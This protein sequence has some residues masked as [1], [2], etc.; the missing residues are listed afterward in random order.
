[1][2]M[3]SKILMT[4]LR[5]HN[6]RHTKMESIRQQLK[7]SRMVSDNTIGKNFLI[8]GWTVGVFVLSKQ[9]N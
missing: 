1:M 3:S 7:Q 5:V 9:Q 4:L 8:H 2:G 6:Y